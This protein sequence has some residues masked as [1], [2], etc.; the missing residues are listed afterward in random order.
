MKPKLA[1]AVAPLLASLVLTGCV[2]APLGSYFRP[3]LPAFA[4]DK[5]S[6]R[7]DMCYGASGA[8]VSLQ[9]TLDGGVVLSVASQH[10]SGK[11]LQLAIAMTLPAGHR[12]RMQSSQLSVSR[13]GQPDQDMAAAWQVSSSGTLP[14]SG[15]SWPGLRPTPDWPADPA[16]TPPG[17]SAR[18]SVGYRLP[19]FTPQHLRL[20]LPAL[21]IDKLA[22]ADRPIDLIGMVSAVG[23]QR[24]YRD[25]PL[26]QAYQATLAHCDGEPPSRSG[27]SCAQVADLR[28]DTFRLLQGPLVVTG[29]VWQ[30][31]PGE[32]QE[33]QGNLN[34]AIPS[35]M[36]VRWQTDR[37][38]LQAE[39]GRW[40]E[41]ELT[42]ARYSLRYDAPLD[43]MLA[44]TAT[45]PIGASTLLTLDDTPLDQYRITLPPAML[46]GHRI[47]FP[48]IELVRHRFDFGLLPF[49]C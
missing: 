11:P 19:E 15:L 47:D 27:L 13:H 30:F 17:F 24:I 48:P 28:H 39:D 9:A 6:Y 45:A 32:D 5:V 14:A 37:L 12:L 41:V 2:P 46:D 16:V 3:S 43:T 7:G 25:L 34:Y 10:T 29:R 40:R 35:P 26:Q 36:S 42:Q 20:V 31:H 44:A 38:R 22:I 1:F 49:N 21:M 8:P 23:V 4:S 18:V 33:L